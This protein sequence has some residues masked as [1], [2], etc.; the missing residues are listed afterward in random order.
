MMG[1]MKIL[2]T[3][4]HAAEWP[5]VERGQGMHLHLEGGRTLLDFTGGGTEHA[6]LGWS[7]PEIVEAIQQQA[8]RITHVD[9][10]FY[11]ER[12]AL[13]LADLLVGAA[14]NGMD[15]VYFAGNS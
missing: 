12:N 1:S 15:R 5:L 7:H 9:V 4:P 2:R 11:A 3:F 14:G 10:K 6:V 8:T 13:E